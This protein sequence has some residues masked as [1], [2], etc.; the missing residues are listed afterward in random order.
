MYMT[1]E[2]FFIRNAIAA[3][4]DSYTEAFLA[5]DEPIE[6][7]YEVL[8]DAAEDERTRFAY[9]YAECV[10]V[11]AEDVLQSEIRVFWRV[12]EPE[13]Y[14]DFETLS[15]AEDAYEEFLTMYYEG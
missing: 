4:R 8:T 7:E 3:E 14:E 6:L 2:Q 9:H 12:D 10:G 15:E 5:S 13:I 1:M 11:C